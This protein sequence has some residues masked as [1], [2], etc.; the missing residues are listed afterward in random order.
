LKAFYEK[1]RDEFANDVA[2]ADALTKGVSAFR[3]TA[4]GDGAAMVAVARAIINTDVFI[5]RE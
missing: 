1:Q 5:T 4:P 3:N 2:A